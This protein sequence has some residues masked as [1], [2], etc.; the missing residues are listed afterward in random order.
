MATGVTGKAEGRPF[1][2]SDND[3]D[4]DDRGKSISNDDEAEL[5]SAQR[6][7]ST[8]AERAAIGQVVKTYYR[9]ASAGDGAA[10]CVLLAQPLAS[11]LP[12]SQASHGSRQTCPQSLSRLF[13][14]Q[15]SHLV[16]E[17]APTMV[18]TGVHVHGDVAFVTLGFRAMPEGELLLQRE[19]R[20]WKLNALF[21]SGLP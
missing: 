5:V 3:R 1:L 2:K 15:R 7:G 11:S 8:V 20:D 10:G 9:A 13:A 14:A 21:D 4:P 18:L 12:P 19:G 6:Y 16:A 17:D